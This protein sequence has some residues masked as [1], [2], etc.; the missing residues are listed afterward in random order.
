M[1]SLSFTV[2][3]SWLQ[4]T[5][6]FLMHA[7]SVTNAVTFF[8]AFEIGLP[9][10]PSRAALPGNHLTP[11]QLAIP[12]P[13]VTPLPQLPRSKPSNC[14]TDSSSMTCRIRLTPLPGSFLQ[15]D[16]IPTR[17]HQLTDIPPFIAIPLLLLMLFQ[18]SGHLNHCVPCIFLLLG[19]M[20]GG[21]ELYQKE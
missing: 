1:T 4:T 2:Y 3:F 21:K 16:H 18:E 15:R 19:K 13:S 7:N 20:E 6:S 11:G 8:C 5:A 14:L 17:L 9:P 12:A 10:I